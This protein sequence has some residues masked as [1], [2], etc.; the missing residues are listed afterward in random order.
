VVAIVQIHFILV[1]GA[2]EQPAS[3]LLGKLQY[4]VR[5]KRVRGVFLPPEHRHLQQI[6]HCVS[7]LVQ[8][9]IDHGAENGILSRNAARQ[10][11]LRGIFQ[12]VGEKLITDGDD[13]FI[14]PRV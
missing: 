8:K 3:V 12:D 1:G 7:A 6:K 14:V 11:L 9:N 5:R 2:Q 10:R 4:D 13:V